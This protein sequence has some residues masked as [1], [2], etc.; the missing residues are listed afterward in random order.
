MNLEGEG[1]PQQVDKTQNV[2]V[3]KRT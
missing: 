1:V 3:V 2:C